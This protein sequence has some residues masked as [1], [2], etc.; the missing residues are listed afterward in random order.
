MPDDMVANF[1]MWRYHDKWVP[2]IIQDVI[3]EC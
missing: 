3:A 2:K 1:Q